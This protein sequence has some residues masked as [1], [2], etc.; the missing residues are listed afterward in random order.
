MNPIDIIKIKSFVSNLH[1]THF[2]FDSGLLYTRDFID[3]DLIKNIEE[4]PCQIGSCYGINLTK[5]PTLKSFKNF[6]F[7]IYGSIFIQFQKLS[8]LTELHMMY[9]TS[10]FTV[11]SCGLKEIGEMP[12]CKLHT[13]YIKYNFSNNY[14]KS[15]KGLEN[16]NSNCLLNVSDNLLRNLEGAPRWINSLLIKNNPMFE[17]FEGVDKIKTLSFSVKDLNHAEEL[18]KTL[19]YVNIKN[20]MFIENDS[21]KKEQDEIYKLFSTVCKNICFEDRTFKLSA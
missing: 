16:I 4:I 7:E 8:S 13:K 11:S 1:L 21:E 12:E 17:S 15:L 6:P 9:C 2:N 20:E 3:L 5:Y 18:Y 19:R 14:L 10:N